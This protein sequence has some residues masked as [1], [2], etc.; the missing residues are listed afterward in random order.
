[1]PGLGSLIACHELTKALV[2]VNVGVWACWR[3]GLAAHDVMLRHLTVYP[4]N[5]PTSW[6]GAAFRFPV[7]SSLFS[8]FFFQNF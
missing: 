1:M 5:P 3:A 4:G 6:L 8:S 2:G 7:F